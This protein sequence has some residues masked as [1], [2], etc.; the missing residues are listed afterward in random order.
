MF[1]KLSPWTQEPAPA[2]AAPDST[3]RAR[4]RVELWVEYKRLHLGFCQTLN[5]LTYGHSSPLAL[6]RFAM[7]AEFEARKLTGEEPEGGDDLTVGDA[8]R[9]AIIRSRAGYGRVAG[10]T[11]D[12]KALSG[13]AEEADPHLIQ[14]ML[15]LTT[16]PFDTADAALVHVAQKEGLEEPE[17]VTRFSAEIRK[18]NAHVR[19]HFVDLARRAGLA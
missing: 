13:L 5:S 16:A 3:A 14:L 7:L 17:R 8:M 9:Q 12:D 15:N 1:N 4:R 10:R 18:L 6:I 19:S 2:A 11:F